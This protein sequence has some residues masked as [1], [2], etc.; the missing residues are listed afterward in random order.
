MVAGP[1]WYWE[2][3]VERKFSAGVCGVK[4][5]MGLDFWSTPTLRDA[6]D[7]IPEKRGKKKD[8][9]ESNR[10]MVVNLE[11]LVSEQKEEVCSS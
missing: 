6:E 11:K 4:R 2:L 5:E 3:W 8:Q 9:K 1:L 10:K 7:V